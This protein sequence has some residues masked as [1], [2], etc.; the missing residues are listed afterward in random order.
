MPPLSIKITSSNVAIRKDLLRNLTGLE[1]GIAQKWI[2][3]SGGKT[4]HPVRM[5]GAT[6]KMAIL[7][8]AGFAET[9]WNGKK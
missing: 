4:N 8:E 7:P 6:R 9:Q 2:V 5:E 3:N 1:Y